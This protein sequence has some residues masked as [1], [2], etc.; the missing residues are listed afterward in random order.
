MKALSRIF[1]V[2]C[3]LFMAYSAFTGVIAGISLIPS[4][5]YAV[6]GYLICFGTLAG[7]I[8]AIVLNIF[9]CKWSSFF[10]LTGTTIFRLYTALIFFNRSRQIIDG[11]FVKHHV[12]IVGVAVFALLSTI[13][14]KK[15]RRDNSVSFEKT[16]KDQE[17]ITEKLAEEET[18]ASSELV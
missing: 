15:Y 9:K 13:C 10:V 2:L 4:S 6:F 12:W 1:S 3:Y 14:Y 16:K 11:V 17:K 5:K 7:F 8:A 18:G